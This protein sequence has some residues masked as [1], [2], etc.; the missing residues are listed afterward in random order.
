LNEDVYGVT[1]GNRLGSAQIHV[2]LQDGRVDVTEPDDLLLGQ[3]LFQEFLL[4]LYDFTIGNGAQHLDEFLL[5]MVLGFSG[6]EP[7]YQ[8]FE[9]LFS[10]F[11]VVNI[12]AHRTFLLND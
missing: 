7:E 4:D 3:T 11:R 9:F 10:E 8:F 5:H 6:V 2:T 1:I 12:L